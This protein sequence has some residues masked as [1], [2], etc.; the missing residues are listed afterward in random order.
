MKSTSK[1]TVRK[2]ASGTFRVSSSA[3]RSATTGQFVH[4]AGT[5]NRFTSAPSRSTPPRAS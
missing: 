3:T 4:N 5:S 2:V 1:T